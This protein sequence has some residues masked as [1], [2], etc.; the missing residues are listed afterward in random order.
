MD[1]LS[2]LVLGV[3]G[4][5]AHVYEGHCSSSFIILKND[6]PF[7]LVDLGLGV[8]R[9]LKRYGYQIPDKIIITHNH[10][11]HAGE[12]PVVLRVEEAQGKQLC[13]YS[14]K[15]V[16]ERL[17]KHRIAEHLDL[18]CSSELAQWVSPLPEEEIQL[19]DNL[20][21]AF[22]VGQHSECCF[23]FVIYQQKDLTESVPLI[24]YTA[25]SGLY[26]ELYSKI[27]QCKYSIYDA[28]EF[29][30]RWHASLEE[31][32]PFL[33]ND[34]YIIGH[35]IEKV[36]SLNHSALLFPGQLINIER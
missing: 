21:I 14:A 6:E 24:G 27:T 32:N 17:R 12:L 15:P 35:G 18:Y 11:D 19:S 31:V 4:G 7:C 29:G 34:S 5:A 20:S 23:G 8:T 22:Y 10:T 33:D 13:I 26:P 36:N 25:D 16:S 9:S 1:K 2:I 30:N 3:A 28:R